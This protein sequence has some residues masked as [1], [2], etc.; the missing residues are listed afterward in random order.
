MGVGVIASGSSTRA[1][2]RTTRLVGLG[3]AGAIFASASSSGADLLA[4]AFLAGAFLAGAFL[5]GAFLAGAFLA[6]AFL[7]GAC[8]VIPLESAKRRTRSPIASS[9]L[10]E[11][12]VAPIFSSLAS[13]STTSLETPYSRAIS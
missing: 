6:G 3:T 9:K 8:R 7:T 1:E 12:L 11:W 4:G 13:S 5:A 10:A 2:E